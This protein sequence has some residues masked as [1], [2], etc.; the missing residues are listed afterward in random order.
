MC[1]RAA[2]ARG[3]AEAAGELSGAR[4]GGAFYSALRLYE[5][6]GFRESGRLLA[7]VAVGTLRFDKV[8]CMLDLR[9]E[10]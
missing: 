4:G 6:L 1:P 9:P 2:R 7:F 3:E 5:S 8:F 10:Q